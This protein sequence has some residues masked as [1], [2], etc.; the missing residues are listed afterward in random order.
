MPQS[1]TSRLMGFALVGGVCAALTF[2]LIAVFNEW[3]HWNVYVG[4]G[5]AYFVTILLSYVLNAMLVFR[6]RLRWRTMLR[7]VLVYLSSLLLGLALLRVAVW[8]LP[9][10]NPTLQSYIVIPFTTLYNF[11]F[12]NC[13]LKK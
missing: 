9:K 5:V 3:L 7:Y 6:Q 13:L 2:A 12:V 10:L 11:L 8:L 1:L 4:Y